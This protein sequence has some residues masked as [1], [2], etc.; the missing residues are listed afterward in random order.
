M[1]G[2]TE[3]PGNQVWAP[4]PSPARREVSPEVSPEVSATSEKP[5]VT[6]R[7]KPGGMQWIAAFAIFFT[8]WGV[9]L[10]IDVFGPTV[11]T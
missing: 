10:T 6:R 3:Q 8:L 1:N 5:R 2:G 11:P 7:S 4:P 9:T